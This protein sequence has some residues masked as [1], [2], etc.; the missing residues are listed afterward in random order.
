MILSVSLSEIVLLWQLLF[1]LILITLA[2]LDFGVLHHCNVIFDIVS[3]HHIVIVDELIIHHLVVAIV[4][5]KQIL[6]LFVI[7]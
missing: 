5:I 1:V 7:K 4:L 6:H 3:K 2:L